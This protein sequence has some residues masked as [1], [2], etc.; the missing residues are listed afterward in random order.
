MAAGLSSA[1][2]N[3]REGRSDGNARKSK[4]VPK[5]AVAKG[6]SPVALTLT[7]P[8]A[9][10]RNRVATN[11]LLK[12]SAVHT[13]AQRRDQ[14]R[15]GNALEVQQGIQDM[16]DSHRIAQDKGRDKDDAKGRGD[17]GD[18]D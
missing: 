17:S 16:L 9:K 15:R 12:K 14:G 8:V 13:D 1:N 6:A 10:P 2:R 11:P 4:S 7:I 18:I 3:E 5:A